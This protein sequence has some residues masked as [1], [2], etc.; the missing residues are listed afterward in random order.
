[1]PQLHFFEEP[2]LG[3][4]LSWQ[5]RLM[6]RSALQRKK[7]QFFDCIGFDEHNR[8]SRRN[9]ILNGDFFELD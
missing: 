5:Y 6:F 2:G 7:I 8:K 4:Y 1:M 3:R 9:K